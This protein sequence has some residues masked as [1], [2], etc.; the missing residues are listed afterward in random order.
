MRTMSLDELPVR[1]G[2]RKIKAA[3]GNGID[4]GILWVVESRAWQLSPLPLCEFY[5]SVVSCSVR[6]FPR[7]HLTVT[8]Y[9]R[10]RSMAIEASALGFGHRWSDGGGTRC[11]VRL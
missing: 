10:Q 5:E 9:L 7:K 2:V 6:S 11:R 1:L 3:A 8:E 4:P